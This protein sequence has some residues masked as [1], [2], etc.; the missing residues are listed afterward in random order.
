MLCENKERLLI[1]FPLSLH[2]FPFLLEKAL[3]GLF[4]ERVKF[5]KEK[6]SKIVFSMCSCIMLV[7]AV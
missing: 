2:L 1:F 3:K 4:I 6:G 5:R 7:F